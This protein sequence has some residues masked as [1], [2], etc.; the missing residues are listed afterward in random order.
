M[1]KKIRVL[2]AWSQNFRPEVFSPYFEG[3]KQ[4]RK[5]IFSH[6][7]GRLAKFGWILT[8][9]KIAHKN[10]WAICNVHTILTESQLT[11]MVFTSW[12]TN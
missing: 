4:H 3:K 8:Y 5:Y 7:T 2:V 10:T 1:V 9:L 6:D 11:N 12:A